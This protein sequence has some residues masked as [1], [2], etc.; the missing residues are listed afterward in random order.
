M[1]DPISDF[2]SRLR[3][4]S[5]AGLAECVTPHSKLKESLATIL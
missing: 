3:P 1:T 4:A 5:K 2:L